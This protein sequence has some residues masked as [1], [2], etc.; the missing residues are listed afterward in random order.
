MAKLAEQ[1][2]PEFKSSHGNTEISTIYSKTTDDKTIRQG[3]KVLYF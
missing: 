2:D 3:G 1:E